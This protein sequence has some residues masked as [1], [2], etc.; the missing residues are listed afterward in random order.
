MWKYDNPIYYRKTTNHFKIFRL[1]KFFF[2]YFHRCRKRNSINYKQLFLVKFNW[3]KRWNKI[4][5]DKI[6]TFGDLDCWTIRQW[7]CSGTYTILSTVLRETSLFRS[8]YQKQD[9]TI[10]Q[11]LDLTRPGKVRKIFCS[12]HFF[13]K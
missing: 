2:F 10:E 3:W 13:I 1:K 4:L 11:C 12:C 5:L 9:K 8:N 6:Q 7:W